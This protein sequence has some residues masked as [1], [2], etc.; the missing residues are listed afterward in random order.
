[1]GERFDLL[2]E[3]PSGEHSSKKEWYKVIMKRIKKEPT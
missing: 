1:M 3:F 2:D